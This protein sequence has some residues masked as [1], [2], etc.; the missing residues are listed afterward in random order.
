MIFIRDGPYKGGIYKFEIKFPSEYPTKSPEV[1]FQTNIL[2]PLIQ[3][4]TGKL[5]LIKFS[6][7]ESG[8]NYTIQVI[9]F[10]QEI[11]YEEAYFLEDNSFNPNLAVLA[12]E[13]FPEFVKRARQQNDV[14]YSKRFENIENS[15]I[16]FTKFNEDHQTIKNKILGNQTDVDQV[17][18]IDD[19]KNWFVN[20]FSEHI[21]KKK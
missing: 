18:R 1:Y 7:W 6:N 10:I 21:V 12:K 16:V 3:E 9:Y 15:S 2:H 4:T 14:I 8:K 17:D 11:F 13:N 5:D 20:N 19:F